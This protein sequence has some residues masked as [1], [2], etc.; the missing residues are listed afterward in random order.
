MIFYFEAVFAVLLIIN[1]V[2]FAVIYIVNTPKLVPF[3]VAFADMVK[4]RMAY[5]AVSKE[6]N[7]TFYYMW[8]KD[9][10]LACWFEG[11]WIKDES[12]VCVLKN[13]LIWTSTG[14]KIEKFEKD[15]ENGS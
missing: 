9:G 14:K 5:K 8:H 2:G 12:S 6:F 7:E 13:K 4:N 11:S 1:V 15:L 10:W 3:H